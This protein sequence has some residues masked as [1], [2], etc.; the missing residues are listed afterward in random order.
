MQQKRLNPVKA[1]A[2]YRA[3]SYSYMQHYYLKPQYYN[4]TSADL[5]NGTDPTFCLCLNSYQVPQQFRQINIFSNIGLNRRKFSN[6]IHGLLP[7]PQDKKPWDNFTS[8]FWYIFLKQIREHRQIFNARRL[9]PKYSGFNLLSQS[10]RFEL[11]IFFMIRA[12]SQGLTNGSPINRTP[13]MA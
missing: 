1:N 11:F 7:M 10:V 2:I 12:R 3:R 9:F 4:R 6:E 8:R 5:Y 13:I